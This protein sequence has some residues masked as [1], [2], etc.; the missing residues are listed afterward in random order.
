[1]SSMC[2]FLHRLWFEVVGI[3]VI[4]DQPCNL[5]HV[6]VRK[7]AHVV[8]AEGVSHQNVGPSDVGTMQCGV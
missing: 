6:Q 5:I 2:L 1:V 7:R 3:G 8:A 4:Q